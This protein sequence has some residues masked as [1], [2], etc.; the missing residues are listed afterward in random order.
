M[1]PHAQLRKQI[2][3]ALRLAEDYLIS[4]EKRMPQGIAGWSSQ[5]KFDYP[6]GKVN[7]TLS[8]EIPTDTVN[9]IDTP[10][11]DTP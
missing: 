4:P 9:H 11:Q 3:N 7:I 1:S 8:V 5:F 10:I 2:R 6:K